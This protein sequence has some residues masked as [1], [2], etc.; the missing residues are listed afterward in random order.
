MKWSIIETAIKFSKIS[1][2]LSTINIKLV[3]INPQLINPQI[4]IN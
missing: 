3:L 2:F 4:S 1:I